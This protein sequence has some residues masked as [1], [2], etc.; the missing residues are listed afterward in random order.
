MSQVHGRRGKRGGGDEG[1]RGVESC[2]G[3]GRIEKRCTWNII[4]LCNSCPIFMIF[5]KLEVV[6]SRKSSS[7]EE[8]EKGS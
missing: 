5:K 7:R 3:E 2:A 6:R 8:G 4:Y 1:K